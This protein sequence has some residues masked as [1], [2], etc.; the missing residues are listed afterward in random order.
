MKDWDDPVSLGLTV[1]T[2]FFSQDGV[3]SSHTQLSSGLIFTL[4]LFTKTAVAAPSFIYSFLSISARIP[5]GYY[6]PEP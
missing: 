4:W 3:G 6:P 1:I 2:V 5:C